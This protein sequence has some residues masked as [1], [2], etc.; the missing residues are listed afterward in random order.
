MALR[1][2]NRIEVLRLSWSKRSSEQQP[3][4]EPKKNSRPQIITLSVT[5]TK[6]KP[7]GE[8]HGAP[9]LVSKIEFGD[10]R[11]SRSGSVLEIPKWLT[12]HQELSA[13]YEMSFKG[14]LQSH[15]IRTD[16]V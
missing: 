11:P 9:K 7:N 5:E 1:S 6:I 2:A 4:S 10:E 8:S 3:I 13:E 12:G 15:G 16:V 14:A